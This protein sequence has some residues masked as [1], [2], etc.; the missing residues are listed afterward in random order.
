MTKRPLFTIPFAVV[1]LGAT[2]AFAIF[3]AYAVAL[4]VRVLPPRGD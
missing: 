3:F 4:T 1:A 2:I